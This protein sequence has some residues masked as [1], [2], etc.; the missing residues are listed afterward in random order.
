MKLGVVPP[1]R[2][3][4]VRMRMR[5]CVRTGKTEHVVVESI[6]DFSMWVRLIEGA[7]HFSPSIKLKGPI[8]EPLVRMTGVTSIERRTC[9]KTGDPLQETKSSIIL[10]RQ[11]EVYANELVLYKDQKQHA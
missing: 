10:G 4:H 5:S 9:G 11:A 7:S 3:E 6:A 8:P 2:S 1:L